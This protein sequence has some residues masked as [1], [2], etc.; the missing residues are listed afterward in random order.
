MKKIILRFFIGLLLLTMAACASSP[1]ADQP[2]LS[3]NEEQELKLTKIVAVLRHGSLQVYR[4]RT[5]YYFVSPSNLS[6][7]SVENIGSIGVRRE[8]DTAMLNFVSVGI[9][10][11]AAYSKT[12]EQDGNT[13]VADGL[14]GIDSLPADAITLIQNGDSTLSTAASLELQG[15]SIRESDVLPETLAV[16]SQKP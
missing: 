9:N 10:Q 11:V 8:E 5:N 2:I 6:A 14:V 1:S 7:D 16:A 13:L 3:E 15:I 12:L 4:D